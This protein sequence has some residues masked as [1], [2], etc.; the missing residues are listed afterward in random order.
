MLAVATHVDAGEGPA[1][2]SLEDR[3]Q[4]DVL[5]K[6]ASSLYGK[7]DYSSAAAIYWRLSEAPN[8]DQAAW[9]LELYGACQEQMGERDVALAIYELWLQRYPGTA[10]E[11][12]V[13]QRRLALLTASAE[14]RAARKQ[15][16]RQDN[17]PTIYGSA[18]VM[19]RGLARKLENQESETP[20]SSL[21]GDM[22]LHMLAQ[23]GDFQWN[24]RVSGGYL[25]DQ[26]DRG[27]S[28]GRVSNL[29]VGI[30]HDPTGAEL[31]LGRQR[32][33]EYGVY[34]YFD[35]V[36]FSYPIAGL[37]TVTVMGG[38]VADNS[39]D[40]PS[41]DHKV[42]GLSTE[43][44]LPDPSLRLRF[45][46]V[47]QTYDGIT[48]R[49]AVGGEFSYF[50]D[51]S[52]Y[53]LIADY[54]LEFQETNNLM[55]NGSWGIGDA[56]NLALS[57]GYQRSPFLSASNALIGE[58]DLNLD[59]LV[60]GLPDDSDI[61]DAALDKTAVSQ[62]ASLVLNHQLS[63]RLR[64]VG[65]AFYYELS[66]LPQY[67]PT[68]KSPDSDA[69]TTLGLQF[70]VD[71]ALFDNDILSTGLRYTT[72]DVTE[73]AVV[74]VDEKLRLDANIDLIFRLSASYRTLT[75]Y[76]QD[77][78]TVRPGIKLDWYFTP[79]FLLDMEAGYEWLAQ[80]FESENFQI[81]QGFIVLGL[82]KRF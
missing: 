33:S 5:L 57:L 52:Y 18:S 45:Y 17:E 10:G 47:E 1:S 70:I 6:E 43:I 81:H 60:S 56:T 11:V 29:Y 34:G 76:N 12:R 41:S 44:H 4:V 65:E 23:T 32:S 55:F 9:A 74:Y 13:Q 2:A 50:N 25:Q 48:E 79:D 24:S 64:V 72:G 42:Y 77:A 27:D 58:Y 82:R 51:Y 78:Y 28:D 37:T 30:S 49:R 61:Y 26:S 16:D 66:D 39:R 40:A 73:T 53:L 19:Y 20:I 22:D 67:D 35:G 59:Q 8:A 38:T 46:G 54:D 31:T 21:A 7:K 63:D 3:G 80:D 15:A 36:S 62:Y 68:Y 14:P 75:D 71:Q 69:N